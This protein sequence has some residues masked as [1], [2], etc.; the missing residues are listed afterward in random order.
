MKRIAY[1]SLAIT[2]SI[3]LLVGKAWAPPPG[4]SPPGSL[5]ARVAAL[6]SDV[7][8][9]QSAVATLETAVSALEAQNAAQQVQ[10]DA[11][12]GDLSAET[13][14]RL[15]A[16][17]SLATA[18]ETLESTDAVLMGKIDGLKTELDVETAARMAADAALQASLAAETAARESADDTLQTQIDTIDA[19]ALEARI[20]DLENNTVIDLDGMLKLDSSSG[21]DTALFEGVRVEVVNGTEGGIIEATVSGLTIT[22]EGD[23]SLVGVDVNLDAGNDLNTIATNTNIDSTVKTTMDSLQTEIKASGVMTLKGSKIE[24]N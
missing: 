4:G 19:T 7:A 1:V 17:A 2:A 8:A 12:K 24:L 21:S 22:S 14:A 6:Q 3:I 23:L 10:I 11:L 20:S 13:A 15:A 5:V 9:L 18:V 16:D